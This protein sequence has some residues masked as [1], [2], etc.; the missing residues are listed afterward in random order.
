V[1][2]VAESLDEGERPQRCTLVRRCVRLERP[3]RRWAVAAIASIALALAPRAGDAASIGFQE[4]DSFAAPFPAAQLLLAPT[5]QR[6]IVRSTAA[7]AAVDTQTG[8]PSVHLPNLIFTDI[9]LSPSG[10]YVYAADYG[11]E[12]FGFEPRVD[13]S[14]VHRLDLQTNVWE[15]VTA[16]VAGHVQV[17]ADGQFLL[18]SLDQWV[19]FSNNLW[20]A[21]GA[22]IPIN[23]P[24]NS[25]FAPGYYPP[26]YAGN[27]RWH[28]AT[29]RLI[30]GNEGSSSREIAAFRLINN[31]F[32]HVEESGTYGSAMQGGGS[33]ALATDG[34][35]FYYGPLK[36]DPLDVSHNL[37][38]FPEPI[39][40]A[41]ADVAFGD[42]RYYDARTGALLGQLG[43]STTV[44]GLH[45]NGQEFWAYDASKGKLRH[46]ALV[47]GEPRPG[48]CSLLDHTFA[49]SVVGAAGGNAS[50]IA[51]ALQVE[52]DPAPGDAHIGVDVGDKT[53]RVFNRLASDATFAGATTYTIS[54]GNGS[55]LSIVG[56]SVAVN[57][58]TGF[59]PANVTFGQKSVT[60]SLA[61]STWHPGDEVTV[62][63][64]TTCQPCSLDFD[65]DGA[66]D[67]KSDGLVL[68]R[69]MFGLTGSAVSDGAVGAQAPRPTWDALRPFLNNIC[70]GNFG[71]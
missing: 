63:L 48:T 26:V 54:L 55:P 5:H 51:R 7:I 47:P 8:T 36:V 45:P 46:Y 40:A 12:N 33:V 57:G 29:G 52:F 49:L 25:Y 35:A 53:V 1:V 34:S 22:A 3:L 18:K 24:T 58:V 20:S 44:Y 71:H 32:A 62:A 31:E 2:R 30:H 41:T 42:G 38:L 15:S 39:H 64:Q 6:L 60:F 27:F 37:K 69:A 23:T 19:V 17:V 50:A 56:I 65:G 4:T 28:A 13:K 16:A 67:A 66:L 10:N 68:L 11:G 14:W 59:T 70:G 21:G 61:G 9:A 43:Y